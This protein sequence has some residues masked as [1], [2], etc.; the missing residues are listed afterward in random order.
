LN[1]ALLSQSPDLR[2]CTAV[3][4]RLAI[5][6]AGARLSLANAGHPAPLH[7]HADGSVEPIIAA[8]TLLGVLDEPA[9]AE[10][11]VNLAVGDS[12]VFYTD[13][14]INSRPDDRQPGLEE[15]VSVVESCVD[16]NAAVTAA[17]ID[18]AL[19]S[20]E[21][22]DLRDDAAILVLR[23][24]DDAEAPGEETDPTAAG[25]PR[26]KMRRLAW[27]RLAGRGNGSDLPPSRRVSQSDPR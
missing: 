24:L 3:L 6:S 22:G 18:T 20:A 23:I 15:L 25:Q 13:G 17:S 16:L 19:L 1:D 12:V 2:I 26:V 21:R 10:A 14:L 5:G 7:L 27:P 4:A 11:E 8:G 9:L